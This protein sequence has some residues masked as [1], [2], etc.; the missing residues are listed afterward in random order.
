MTVQDFIQNSLN[1]IHVNFPNARIEYQHRNNSDTHFVKVTP[2]EVYDTETF[3]DLDFEFSEEFD[4][5]GFNGNFCIITEGSLVELDNPQVVIEPVSYLV[6]N[7]PALDEISNGELWDIHCRNFG[8]LKNG[9]INLTFSDSIVLIEKDII[10]SNPIS[11]IHNSLTK[12][13]LCERNFA[14]AA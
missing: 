3:V 14:M 2:L 10:I 12:D 7:K 4:S 9:S 13:I 11:S 8:K 1:K 6:S 5:L